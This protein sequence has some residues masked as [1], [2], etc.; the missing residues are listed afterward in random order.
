MTT[1]TAAPAP[2]PTVDWDG[3]ID[4]MSDAFHGE[5]LARFVRDAAGLE[6]TV[7]HDEGLWRHLRFR[8]PRTGLYWFDIITSPGL[9]TFNGDTGTFVFSRLPDMLE[10]FT[11]AYINPGYWGEKLR[12]SSA[13]RNFSPE[14]FA[15]RVR[16]HVNEW[17]TDH[18]W[19]AE[20][21]DELRAALEEDVLEF[22]GTS[23]EAHQALIDFQW[24]GT[25]EGERYGFEFTDSWEWNLE[26]YET[27]YL[28]ACHAIRAAV[29]AYRAHQAATA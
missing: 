9:L 2:A 21:V 3:I 25:H 16:E 6:M 4:A 26:D 22:D 7:L 19:P 27:Q 13:Y 8:S 28:W 17:V 29:I 10:F 20:M 15:Q 18:A 12:A 23:N 1:T 14:L 24:S 5:S 11:G